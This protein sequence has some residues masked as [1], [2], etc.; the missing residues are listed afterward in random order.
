MMRGGASGA[1]MSTLGVGDGVGAA[2]DGTALAAGA[3]VSTCAMDG[4]TAGATVDTTTGAVNAGAG[5]TLMAI[6]AV[7]LCCAADVAATCGA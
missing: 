2:A 7:G 6:V 3:G 5:V 4:T 1:S